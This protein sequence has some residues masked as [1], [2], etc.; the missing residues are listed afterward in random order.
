MQQMPPSIRAEILPSEAQ[1][2]GLSQVFDE[3]RQE[4]GG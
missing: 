4:A 2:V 3:M 1:T